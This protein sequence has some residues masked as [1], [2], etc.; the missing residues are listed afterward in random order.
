MP[1][2]ESFEEP[3]FI[4][5]C[6]RD[7]WSIFKAIH[8]HNCYE[9]YYLESGEITYFIDDEVYPIRHGDFIIIPPGVHHKT[10]PYH[11]TD[12]IR[13]LIYLKEEFLK[14]ILSDKE[15][16]SSTFSKP[17][18]VMG[19]SPIAKR[20]LC[21]LLEESAQDGN[22]DMLRLLTG[23]LMLWLRRWKEQDAHLAEKTPHET[24]E[25]IYDKVSEIAR[26]IN[27]HYMEDVSLSALAKRFYM[28]PSYLSRIFHQVMQVSYSEYLIQV[29]IRHAAQLL[30]HT[31][32][33]ITEIA[34][35]SGFHS[36]NHFCKTFRR[37]MGCSPRKYRTAAVQHEDFL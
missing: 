4:E 2:L 18:A 14:D 21:S 28:T 27:H 35:A 33:K 9:I 30:L 17:L 22:T 1:L 3:F 10:L 11:Q 23:E 36:D 19:R 7:D 24:G 34:L 15:I 13:I 37:V 6:R 5:R 25:R 20:L 26:Y 12:H 31:E 8:F 29:R 16:F 32:E